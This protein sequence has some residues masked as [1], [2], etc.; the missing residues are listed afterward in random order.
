MGEGQAQ[1][2]ILDREINADLVQAFVEQFGQAR[3]GS[4]EGVFGRQRPPRGACGVL[5]LSFF[6]CQAVPVKE[7]APA[8]SVA[9]MRPVTID[10]GLPADLLQVV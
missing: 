1:R 4:V 9:L 2:G 7:F 3:R 10:H 8:A 5:V 6:R